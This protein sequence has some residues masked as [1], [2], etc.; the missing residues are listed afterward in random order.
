MA[1]NYLTSSCEHIK[2]DLKHVLEFG[3][4]KGRSLELIRRTLDDSYQV[5]GFDTFTGLPTDWKEVGLKQGAF[6]TDGEIPQISGVRMF[7][8]LFKD[9]I[10]EYLKVAAPIGLIHIDCDLYES[11]I[12]VLYGLNDYIV[13]GTIM[14]IDDWFYE[15]DPKYNN[16]VQ[17][18]FLEWSKEF[19]RQYKFHSF[20]GCELPTEGKRSVEII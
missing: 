13:P 12:D 17:K 7:K 18:A 1:K 16:H 6:S 15:H 9:T 2:K 4:Y 5:F 8:G 10:P 14:A 19:S 11:T 20:V 3:V